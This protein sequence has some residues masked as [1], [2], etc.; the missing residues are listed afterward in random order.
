A[1]AKIGV[2]KTEY[3]ENLIYKRNTIIVGHLARY[4]LPMLQMTW[5]Y[6]IYEL[7]FCMKEQCAG[8]SISKPALNNLLM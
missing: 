4:I 8:F 2:N 1:L 6:V 7:G 3:I 5:T